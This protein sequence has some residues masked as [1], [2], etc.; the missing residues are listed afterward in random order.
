MVKEGGI[1]E[2]SAAGK[3][4]GMLKELKAEGYERLVA[5]EDPA[6]RHTAVRG[7]ALGGCR[8]QGIAPH[9]AANRLAEES[10][11]R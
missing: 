8:M 5:W 9:R 10:L 1:V 2:V 4:I 3:K 11:K 7:P 6:A